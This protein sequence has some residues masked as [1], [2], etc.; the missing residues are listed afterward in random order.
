MLVPNK[1]KDLN[2]FQALFLLLTKQCSLPRR[3]LSNS[4]LYPQ[5][6]YISFIYSQPFIHHFTGLFGTNIITSSQL[7]CQLSWQSA[8]PASH[9]SWVQIPYRPQFFF[10]ALFSLLLKQC[11]LRSLSNSRLYPQFKYMTIIYSRLLNRNV[12]HM[13]CIF[14]T[15]WKIERSQQFGHSSMEIKVFM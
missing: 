11:S 6:K 4:R 3:S 7:A 5:F 12:V 9:R 10:Q 8:A 15:C 14:N 1:C 2:F 13:Q